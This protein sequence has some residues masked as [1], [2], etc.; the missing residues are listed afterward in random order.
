VLVTV[1]SRSPQASGFLIFMK[2]TP[3]TMAVA[4]LVAG[5]VGLLSA[6]I[7]SYNASRVNIVEGLRHI[8]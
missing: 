5:L 6:V 8:G 7:P 3:G 4:L 2:V 1:F